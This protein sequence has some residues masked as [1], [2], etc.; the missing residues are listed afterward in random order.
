M[1]IRSACGARAVRYACLML[2]F[3]AALIV[4]PITVAQH[5]QAATSASDDFTR[6]NGSLGPNWTDIQDGGLAISSDAA[7]GT[8]ASGNSGDMWTA[9][10]FTSDQ[11]SQI[12]LTSTQLTGSQWI[13]AAVRMQNS[14]LYAYV[15]LYFWNFGAPELMLFRRQGGGWTQLGNTYS[16]GPLPAGTVLELTAVGS[17]LSFIENGTQRIAVSDTAFTGGAP[18]IIANQAAK[19]A[20]WAGGDSSD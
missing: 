9:N 19:A 7:V 16:S 8:S 6:A 10:S 18:G 1:I 20:T 13:G 14:G 15:G 12:T 5:A 3:V 2:A 4:P 17:S 11:F